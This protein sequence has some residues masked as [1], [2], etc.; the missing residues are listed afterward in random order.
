MGT[1]CDFAKWAV[2]LSVA[3]LAQACN[4]SAIPEMEKQDVVD[5]RVGPRTETIL[6]VLKDDEPFVLMDILP[7]VVTINTLTESARR[8]YLLKRAL[9]TIRANALGESQ[10]LDKDTFTVRMILLKDVDEYGR[11]KWGTAPQVALLRLRR[12]RIE[13]LTADDIH[14]LERG[15]VEAM[16]L[17]VEIDPNHFE[18]ISGK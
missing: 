3:A 6:A 4:K 15:Q 11:P 7:E 17:S 9:L 2:L 5:T 14:E 16:F 10:F 18:G 13:P 1:A 8:E 12:E